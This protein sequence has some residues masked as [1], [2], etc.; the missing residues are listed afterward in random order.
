M[1]ATLGGVLLGVG[2]ISISAHYIGIAIDERKKYAKE[3]K[4]RGDIAANDIINFCLEEKFNNITYAEQHKIVN[5]DFQK[6]KSI[7]T[8]TF[9][10][11]HELINSWFSL[12]NMSFLET[13][14]DES[15]KKQQKEYSNRILEYIKNDEESPQRFHKNMRIYCASNQIGEFSNTLP[16]WHS[17]EWH[18]REKLKRQIIYQCFPDRKKEKENAKVFEEMIGKF[19]GT[20]KAITF[21][22]ASS[23]AIPERPIDSEEIK[24][25]E[26]ELE[27]FISVRIDKNPEIRKTFDRLFRKYRFLGGRCEF[28]RNH[29]FEMENFEQYYATQKDDEMTKSMIKDTVFRNVVSLGAFSIV[30]YMCILTHRLSDE[31]L[32]EVNK[33]IELM[34]STTSDIFSYGIEYR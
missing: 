27:K 25:Y 23:N 34:R 26:T 22:L 19:Y 3:M 14:L 12:Q 6:E 13:E 21:L 5:I 31:E 16:K 9:N 1:F 29:I 17:T 15:E 7:I 32:E 8:F 20:Y 33:N 18:S 11:N 4:L 10:R 30:N 24:K 2:I 28:D